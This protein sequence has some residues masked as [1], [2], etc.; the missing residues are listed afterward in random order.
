VSGL[1]TPEPR[2]PAEA[3]KAAIGRTAQKVLKRQITGKDTWC[4]CGA[5]DDGVV[6]GM[7]D[8]RCGPSHA[9]SGVRE[10]FQVEAWSERCAL[11]CVP[12]T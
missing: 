11:G 4:V 9:G 5:R 12:V 3:K 10:Q 1:G 2:G 6:K 8:L 7:V